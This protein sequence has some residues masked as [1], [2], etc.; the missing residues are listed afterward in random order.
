MGIEGRKEKG[1]RWE[2]LGRKRRKG[3]G[4]RNGKGGGYFMNLD[5]ERK[6]EKRMGCAKG[7]WVDR[8]GEKVGRWGKG[9]E[10]VC[11]KGH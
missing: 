6:K 3:G 7:E 9:G 8:E 1:G 10:R 11:Q 5:K 4:G 2:R